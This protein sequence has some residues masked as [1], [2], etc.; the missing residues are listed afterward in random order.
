[1]KISIIS[2]NYND[3]IGFEKTIES[4]VNQTYQDFEFLV[5][6]G[7][8]SDG[9]TEIIEKYKSKINYWVSEPDSGIYNAMNKGILAAKGE[10]VIFMNAGDIF[11]DQNVLLQVIPL[12]SSE[13]GIYYGNLV[14]SNN[15]KPSKIFVPPSKLTFSFFIDYSLPHPASFIKKELFEKFFYYNEN[16]KIVSDWEFFI[17]CICK[18]NCSYKYLDFT[19]ANFD[20]SGISS[21]PENANK[22]LLERETV[23]QNHFPMFLEDVKSLNLVNSKKIRQIIELK[24]NKLQWKILKAFV[25]I[26]SIF[27]P[28]ITSNVNKYFTNF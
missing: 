7:N 15:Q 26:L 14:F 18:Q 12:L 5:I 25:N 2:I 20:E 4:V 11:Y 8:S 23:L 1:M 17:Y 13:I 24:S 27:K 21:V 16:L 22:I 10:Y 3:K 6:D 28:K 9:S 19:I